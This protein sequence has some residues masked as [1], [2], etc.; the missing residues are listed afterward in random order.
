[1]VT[2]ARRRR[3]GC[4]EKKKEHRV[5]KLSCRGKGAGGK[6]QSVRDGVTLNRPKEGIKGEYGD[7][8]VVRSVFPREFCGGK[9]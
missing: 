4:M 8:T 1:V 5:I 9:T 3:K 7:R 6:E 2:G